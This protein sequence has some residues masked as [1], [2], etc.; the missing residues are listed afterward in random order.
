M[1]NN[2]NVLNQLKLEGNLSENWKR[3]KQSF[4]DD[5]K[6]SILLKLIGEDALEVYNTFEN[7]SKPRTYE[8]EIKLYETYCNPK[9]K[10]L[11]AQFLFYNR[12]QRKGESFDNFLT[13]IRNL[14][15]NCEFTNKE[16]L[17]RDK[18]V[19]GTNDMET[20]ETYKNR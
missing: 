14:A 16:E 12:K 11:H 7:K 1:A 13:E 8:D 9:K 18:M 19:L 4:D 5:R 15:Q 2:C 6:I 17:I 3:F 10:N 20:Q